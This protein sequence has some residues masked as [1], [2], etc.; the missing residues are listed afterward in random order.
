MSNAI[1]QVQEV[2]FDLCDLIDSGQI[3]NFRLKG[4]Q[5]FWTLR[6][7]L[8]EQKAKLQ[9]IEEDLQEVSD[10]TRSYGPRGARA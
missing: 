5:E 4:F 2:F 6:E 3:D 7:F 1:T 9:S 10:E 8:E